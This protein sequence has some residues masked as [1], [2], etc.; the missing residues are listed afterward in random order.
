VLLVA[1]D[2]RAPL[3]ELLRDEFNHVPVLSFA[4]LQSSA[5]VSVLGRFDLER[6]AL[7]EENVA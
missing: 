7:M 3:R 2:L 4:E 1:Q 5:Q 6:E